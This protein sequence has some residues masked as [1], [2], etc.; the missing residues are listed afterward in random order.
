[1]IYL[2]ASTG[3]LLSGVGLPHDSGQIGESTLISGSPASWPDGSAAVCA[4]DGSLLKFNTAGTFEWRKEGL[5]GGDAGAVLQSSPAILPNGDLVVAASS[6]PEVR[7]LTKDGELVWAFCARAGHTTGPCADGATSA[8]SASPIHTPQ[9]IIV[10][11][12]ANGQVFAVTSEGAE[13]WRYATDETSSAASSLTSSPIVASDGT[14]MVGSASGG[15][16]AVGELPYFSVDQPRL[17][18]EVE[19]GG[20]RETSLGDGRLVAAKTAIAGATGGLAKSSGVIFVRVRVVDPGVSRRVKHGTVRRDGGLR[21]TKGDG[22]RAASALRIAY[23][24]LF[25]SAAQQNLANSLLTT[26]NMTLA[27]R[28]ALSASSVSVTI[29]PPPVVSALAGNSIALATPRP[30]TGLLEGA[31]GGAVQAPGA[32]TTPAPTVG[33]KCDPASVDLGK[34]ACSQGCAYASCRCSDVGYCVAGVEDM[35]GGLSAGQAAL[36][37]AGVLIFLGMAVTCCWSWLFWREEK[38]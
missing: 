2:D 25:D 12:G 14:V 37:I 13:V 16:H 9:G 34:A 35:Q 28:S 10:S 7:R 21:S 30:S 19:V 38:R 29:A 20:V 23:V 22:R 31:S 36:V 32:T 26:L 18:V 3:A 33:V 15:L 8:I 4:S 5:C 24:V 27:I 1:M 6:P 11:G 17:S